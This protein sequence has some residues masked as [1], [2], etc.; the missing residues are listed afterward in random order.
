M[1]SLLLEEIGETGFENEL[2]STSLVNVLE[3]WL[4]T[5]LASLH[6]FHM[7]IWTFVL[8]VA[9]SYYCSIGGDTNKEV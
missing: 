2:T 3:V 4:I 6:N 9:F 1:E 5:F 8:Y 7:I